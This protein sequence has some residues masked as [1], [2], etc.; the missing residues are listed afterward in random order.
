M[1]LR[2]PFR[3]IT[4]T[5]EGD[6]LVVL[7]RAD[8][9]FT[10]R[11][12]ERAIEDA[13]WNGIWKALTRLEEQGIVTSEKAGRAKLF[14]LNREHMATPHIEGIARLRMELIE[15]L[16]AEVASWP[17]Q[18]VSAVLFGSAARGEASKDSD[19]DLL[20]IRSSSVDADDDQWQ[21]QITALEAKATVWTGN[22]ARVLEWAESDLPKKQ[23]VEPVIDDAL[24]EG[25]ELGGT[26]LRVLRR[27]AAGAKRRAGA[28]K[29]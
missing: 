15:R 12:I 21:E 11:E 17:V 2:H 28:A 8:K 19:L 9:A 7:A 1:D 3:V 29:R 6:V 16:R 13:S 20:L 24:A 25:V 27:R 5:L 22:D 18:P 10:G 4:P 26:S 14:R 23:G